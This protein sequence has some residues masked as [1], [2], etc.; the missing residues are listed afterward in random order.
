MGLLDTNQTPQTMPA[1]GGLLG[2]MGGGMQQ[3]PQAGDPTKGLQLAMALSKNPTPDVARQV[4]NIMHQSGSP[5]AEGF[6]TQISQIVNDPQALKQL[7][8]SVIQ[9]ISGGMNAQ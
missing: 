4:I 6:A 5:Q 9:R 2:G 8:D 1:Q 3:Q 7:A